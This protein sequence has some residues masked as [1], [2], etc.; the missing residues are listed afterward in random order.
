MH[1][2]HFDAAVAHL[3]HE[4]EMVALGVFHPQH[5]IEQQIVA[6]ARGQPGMRLARG[7][8]HDLAQLTDFR[9]YAECHIN[10]LFPNEIVDIFKL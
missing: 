1:L 5:V 7:T 6:V 10:F 8:D 4:L 3:H 9:M 2:Q